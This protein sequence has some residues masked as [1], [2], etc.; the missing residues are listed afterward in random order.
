MDVHHICDWFLHR[1]ENI[2][3]PP[4]TEVID[5]LESFFGYWESNLGPLEE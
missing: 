2:N 3:T 4:G 1:T 5:F